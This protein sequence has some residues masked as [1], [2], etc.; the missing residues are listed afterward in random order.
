MRT[1]V[2]GEAAGLTHEPAGTVIA[3]CSL[4]NDAVSAVSTS[5][6]S[7]P[8]LPQPPRLHRTAHPALLVRSGSEAEPSPC[9]A[10]TGDEVGAPA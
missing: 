9:D 1:Q 5:R 3:H 6:S 2:G 8:S 10:V 7:L 4:T